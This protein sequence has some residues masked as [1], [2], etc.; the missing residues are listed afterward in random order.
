[1]TDE[2]PYRRRQHRA[3]RPVTI[4]IVGADGSAISW[5]REDETNL[6]GPGRFAGSADL[7]DTATALILAREPLTLPTGA[8]WDFPPHPALRAVDVAAT[9]LAALQVDA[10]YRPLID[11]FP[12]LRRQPAPAKNGPIK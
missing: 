11:R 12:E 2:I 8:T 3:I 7:V 6:A 9:M 10:D 1:M 4:G 5:S